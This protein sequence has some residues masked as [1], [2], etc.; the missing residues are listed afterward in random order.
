MQNEALEMPVMKLYL[1]DTSPFSRLVLATLLLLR[2]DCTLHWVDPWQRPPTLCAVNPFS[3]I[4]TL[5]IAPDTVLTDSVL[6]GIYLIRHY[7]DEAL[8]LPQNQQD[9]QC[10]SF[11]KQL[12][13][14]AFRVTVLPRFY[15][16]NSLWMENSRL[17]LEAALA[18]LPK[19][20]AKRTFADLSLHIALDYLRLR[21]PDLAAPAYDSPFDGLLHAIRPSVLATHPTYHDLRGYH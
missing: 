11:A 7:P 15:G 19:R 14:T 6:T 8:P 17:A 21:H 16:E 4:P 2:K 1:N 3:T 20:H 18:H 5:V 10:L 9:W 12:M 13:E